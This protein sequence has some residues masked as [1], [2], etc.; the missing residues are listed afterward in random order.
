MGSSPR[1]CREAS[2]AAGVMIEIGGPAFG[3]E[4]HSK[5]CRCAVW[6]RGHG[7]TVCCMRSHNV[8]RRQSEVSFYFAFSFL[9]PW[10]SIRDFAG[11]RLNL[12]VLRHIFISKTSLLFLG[13]SP[14]FVALGFCLNPPPDG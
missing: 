11:L 4:P 5:E 2:G 12:K 14:L 13:N 3:P 9:C 1:S 10:Q 7:T 8:M 6:L